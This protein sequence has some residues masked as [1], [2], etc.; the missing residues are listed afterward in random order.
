MATKKNSVVEPR[1]KARITAFQKGMLQILEEE[2]QGDVHKEEFKPAKVIPEKKVVKKPRTKV[3]QKILTP[4]DME[5]ELLYF[6]DHF[7]LKPPMQVGLHVDTVEDAR[8]RR[9]GKASGGGS[10][11]IEKI[12]QGVEPPRHFWKKIDAESTEAAI[13][14]ADDWIC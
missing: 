7:P 3:S 9:M 12:R 10:D 5:R 8:E 13:I 1:Q 2:L 11:Q 14:P 6:K 4:A